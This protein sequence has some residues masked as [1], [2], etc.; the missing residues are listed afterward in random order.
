MNILK[1]WTIPAKVGLAIVITTATLMIIF[2]AFND[3]FYIATE[4]IVVTK[5][6]ENS[7]YILERN[8]SLLE[9]SDH[10]AITEFYCGIKSVIA[11]KSSE[12]E[13][14]TSHKNNRLLIY[15]NGEIQIENIVNQTNK[16]IGIID[17]A[18]SGDI[19]DD[20]IVILCDNGKVSVLCNYTGGKLILMNNLPKIQK[21]ILG[22][23]SIIALSTAGKVYI[24]GA[25]AGVE[26]QNFA[27]Y[28]SPVKFTDIDCSQVTDTIISLGIDGQVYQIGIPNFFDESL[29]GKGI[30]TANL[31]SLTSFTKIDQMHN[32]RS[33]KVDEL[34]CFVIDNSGYIYCWGSDYKG[35]SIELKKSYYRLLNIKSTM[36]DINL[37][38]NYYINNDNIYYVQSWF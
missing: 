36:P 14:I 10:G 23:S 34:K 19:K 22:K 32:I 27:L 9:L 4:K 20:N 11:E 5:Y 33:I 26:N 2:I 21:V 31:T 24:Y 13:Y 18:R 1:N 15:K 3:K 38:N 7:T 30:E 25:F 28:D 29:S 12:L 6:N 16:K 35:K 17:K 8:N 37:G